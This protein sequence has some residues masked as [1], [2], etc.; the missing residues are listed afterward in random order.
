MNEW[1]PEKGFSSSDVSIVDFDP[2]WKVDD[3]YE[4]SFPLTVIQESKT[5]F[6]VGHGNR[7]GYYTLIIRYSV[8]SV[9]S[10][11]QYGLAIFNCN[12]GYLTLTA[13]KDLLSILGQ[14]KRGTVKMGTEIAER[15]Y[16]KIHGD[17]RSNNANN[18]ED[19]KRSDLKKSALSRRHFATFCY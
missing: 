14:K 3:S 19:L 16:S 4:S 15:V 9:A 6:I 11:I 2:F 12:I 13:S 8:A 5:P 7:G 17:S 1:C 10:G 18:H